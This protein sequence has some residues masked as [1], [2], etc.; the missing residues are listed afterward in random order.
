MIALFYSNEKGTLSMK[1]KMR[2]R[3]IRKIKL[4]LRL[5]LNWRFLICFGIG[6]II[7]NGWS[8]LL[9]GIGILTKSAWMMAISGA[10]LTFLWLPISPE[11]IV[12]VAIALFLVKRL[13][14]KHNTLLRQQILG[15]LDQEP[16]SQTKNHLANKNR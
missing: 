4:W 9:L 6:W 16:T 2:E 13:F 15:A 11:K 14:P 12:T 3:L 7:T 5:I 10:Y 1:P 8:Y